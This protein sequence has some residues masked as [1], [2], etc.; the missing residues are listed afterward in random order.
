MTV[1]LT[2]GILAL[3]IAIVVRTAS[4]GGGSVGYVLGAIFVAAGAARLWLYT[5]Q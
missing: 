4:L 1:W 3:G 5:R 2:W